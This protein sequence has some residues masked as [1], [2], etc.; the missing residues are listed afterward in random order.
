VG[1]VGLDLAEALTRRG[2]NQLVLIDSDEKRCE[3]LAGEVDALVL[4]GDGANPEILKKGQLE[5]A[6]ALVA[7]T[8]SDST[9][10]VIAMLGH[11]QQVKTIVVKLNDTWLWAACR[12]LGVTK[13]VTPKISAAAQML[14]SLYG[15]DRMDFSLGAGEGMRMLEVPVKEGYDKRLSELE[16]PENALVVGVLRGRQMLFPGKQTR[17]QKEDTLVTLV[18]NEG[19]VAQVRKSMGN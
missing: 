7:S 2:G 4:C 9:N 19:A 3:Y 11:N 5:D 16:L 1:D 13:V 10:T 14:E 18:E 8:G 17:L 6:D 12:E 15:F